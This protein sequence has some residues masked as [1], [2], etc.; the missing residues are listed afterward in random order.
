VYER[1]ALVEEG[2][3]LEIEI[4]CS[5]G[6]FEEVERAL[7]LRFLVQAAATVDQGMSVGGGRGREERRQCRNRLWGSSQHAVPQS[8]ESITALDRL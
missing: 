5:L 3:I 8:R 6:P 1:A 2:E 4:R 7:E